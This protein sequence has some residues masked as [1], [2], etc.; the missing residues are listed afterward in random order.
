MTTTNDFKNTLIDVR[1]AYRLLFLYQKRVMELVQFIGDTLSFNY[2]GGWSWFSDG[3]PKNGKGSLEN[4][5]WDWISMY[6]YEF[7]FAIKE[8]NKNKIKFSILL[9]SDTG[10]YDAQPHSKQEVETFLSP[11]NSETKLI[12][13]VGKNC[14]YPDFAIDFEETNAIYKKEL[15]EYAKTVEE[16]TLLAKSFLLSDFINLDTTQ[17]ALIKWVEFCNENGIN[18]IKMQK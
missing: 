8:V 5:S 11:E 10:F 15:S 1:K 14:W 2:Q 4:W 12:F 18:E 16:K 7:N 17:N 3:T 6:F 13:L 9:Q